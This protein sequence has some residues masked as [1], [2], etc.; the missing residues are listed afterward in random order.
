MKSRA[1]TIAELDWINYATGA[2]AIAIRNE[3]SKLAV[4]ASD[5]HVAQRYEAQRCAAC[6]YLRRYRISGQAFTNWNCQLCKEAQPAHHNTG[7]PRLCSPCASTYGLC[8]EC[9]GD[10]ETRH[11]GRMTGRKPK[12]AKP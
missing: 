7:V 1:L 11:R 9:G 8:V 10:L 2:A 3:L 12:R 5:A 6:E 4:L